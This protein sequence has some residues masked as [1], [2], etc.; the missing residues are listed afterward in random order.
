MLRKNQSRKLDYKT[1]V[2]STNTLALDVL[3]V[4]EADCDYDEMAEVIRNSRKL[5][6]NSF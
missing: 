2:Y 6:A 5:A 1:E 3:V 4:D